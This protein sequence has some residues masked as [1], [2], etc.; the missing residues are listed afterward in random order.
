MRNVLPNTTADFNLTNIYGDGD[1]DIGWAFIQ[2]KRLLELSTDD[3]ITIAGETFNV[4]DS[5][6]LRDAIQK[7]MM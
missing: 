5:F 6:V 4:K 7:C 1:L 2:V 3:N